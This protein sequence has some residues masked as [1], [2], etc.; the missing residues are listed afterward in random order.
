[1]FPAGLVEKAAQSLDAC[2][3]KNLKLATA[4]SC[5]GGLVA[6]LLTEIPGS[7]DVF[8]CGFVTYANRAKEKQLDVDASLLRKHGAV[9]AEAAIAMAA[10]A[11]KQCK[12]DIAVSVTGIAGPG[13]ATPNKPVGLVFIA[14]ADGK[15]AAAYEYHFK[16]TRSEVRLAAVMAVI[17]MIYSRL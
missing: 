8:E 14:V 17:E 12:A 5:T 4:E 1:M 9:S 2:R 7:S 16:G 15:G 3:S 6:A 11:R 10:G 13:G